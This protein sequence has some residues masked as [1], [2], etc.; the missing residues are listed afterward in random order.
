MKVPTEKWLTWKPKYHE[1]PEK[2]KHHFHFECLNQ[3]DS[4]M[5]GGR[6]E[7]REDKST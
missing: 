6:V 5:E 4:G 1:F 7:E 2:L 3:I